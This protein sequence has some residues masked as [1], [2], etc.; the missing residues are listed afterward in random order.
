MTASLVALAMFTSAATSKADQSTERSTNTTI[1]E[2][3][4][5]ERF[6]EARRRYDQG[7]FEEALALFRAVLED[8]P[9]PNARL[10]VGRCLRR[11]GRLAEAYNELRRA[12][13]EAQQRAASE[14]RYTATR[15]SARE[16]AASLVEHVAFI[17]LHVSGAPANAEVTL[18]GQRTGPALWSTPIARTPGLCVIEARA[19]GMQP[20]R[21]QVEL[22]AAAETRVRIPFVALNLEGAVQIGFANDSPAS[23]AQGSQGVETIAV[24]RQALD[25]TM[26]DRS[27]HASQ[28]HASASHFEGRAPSASAWVPIGGVTAA[29]GLAGLVTGTVFAVMGNHRYAT[30]AEQCFRLGST[31]HVDPDVQQRVAEG[32]TFDAIAVVGIAAGSTLAVAGVAMIVG[33]VLQNEANRSAT[34]IFAPTVAHRARPS[35][36]AWP[37]SVSLALEGVF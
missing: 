2:R 36:V 27:A 11:L 19:E 14:P 24:D 28:S 35:L 22:R 15:E 33:G 13:Q 29:A 10:Y 30:L 37:S 6:A 8:A 9:S 16:E 34:Q 32:R 3:D 31:C 1:S 17:T 12:A 26:G 4:P 7:R 18:D 23:S 20:I 21:L 25:A 5:A